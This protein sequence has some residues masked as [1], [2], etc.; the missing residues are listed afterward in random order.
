MTQL[1]ER[2]KESRV[3]FAFD[4]IYRRT[5][6]VRVI[7]IE[8]A[9]KLIRL[10][11]SDKYDNGSDERIYQSFLIKKPW[12]YFFLFGNRSNGHR[13]GIIYFSQRRVTHR[14]RKAL[15]YA[16]LPNMTYRNLGFH[17]V[18][19]CFG[20]EYYSGT[21]REKALGYHEGLWETCYT[22]D[23]NLSSM[24]TPSWYQRKRRRW[25][26]FLRAWEEKSQ[27]KKPI[28]FV[29][30]IHASINQAAHHWVRSQP[31]F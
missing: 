13:G 21:L 20:S 11:Y 5:Q 12:S 6:E 19:I 2:N 23:F 26:E 31:E 4:V 18:G 16:P 27:C 29:K 8:D 30:S 22:N 1:M 25:P 9:P 3:S 15:E 24:V 10:H 17:Y 28:E 7:V 14:E